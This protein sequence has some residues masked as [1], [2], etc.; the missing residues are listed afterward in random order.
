MAFLIGDVRVVV[1]SVDL[2]DQAFS[3]DTP[4]ER[5]QVD[6]STF[7]PSGARSFLPGVSDQTI[8]IGFRQ[9][10]ANGKVHQTIEPL[11]RLGSAF[12]IYI[13]PDSDTGTSA[14]NP[15]F[16]GTATV[17]SYN[18]L[19]GELNDSSD[20][21]VEFKPGP[22]AYFRWGTSWPVP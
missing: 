14:T 4:M 15:V 22:N 11:F 9:N 18:G 5:D 3:V 12:P 2:S 21:E 7:S 19:T 10:F 16:G 6:V 1:N 8:T 17:F 20:V 13:V